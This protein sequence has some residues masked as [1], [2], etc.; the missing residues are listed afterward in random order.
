MKNVIW[1]TMAFGLY[2]FIF[3]EMVRQTKHIN[4]H[5]MIE[6]SVDASTVRN[7]IDHQL[8]DEEVYC[9]T[10]NI[11][12]EARNQPD[13]G[14]YAIAYVTLNRM[15]HVNYPD[16]ICDTVY[17]PYQFSWT[18]NNTQVMIN[19][20]IDQNSWDRAENIAKS[21]LSNPYDIPME[22]LG[23]THYHADYVDPPWSRKYDLVNTIGNHLFYRQN[24]M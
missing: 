21:V 14:K 10:K 13:F 19:N 2:F 5:Q 17:D 12:H 7:I 9:L 16:T 3:G 4:E 15:H 8:A 6:I 18:I 1:G 11:F 20:I 23:V 24:I 22:F